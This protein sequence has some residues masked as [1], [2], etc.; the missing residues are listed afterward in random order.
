MTKEKVC[1]VVKKIAK[2]YENN[3][4]PCGYYKPRRKTK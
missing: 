4:S 1:L 2:K 3:Y